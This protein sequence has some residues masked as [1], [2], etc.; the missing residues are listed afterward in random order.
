MGSYLS[1]NQKEVHAHHEE[2]EFLWTHLRVE[3][4]GDIKA[5][6]DKLDADREQ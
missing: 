4:E 6:Q 2:M 1:T 3:M 5:R